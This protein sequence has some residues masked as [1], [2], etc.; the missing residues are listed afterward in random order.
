MK[1]GREEEK[2]SSGANKKQLTISSMFKPAAATKAPVMTAPQVVEGDSTSVE[3]VQD[4]NVKKDPKALFKN[5]DEETL[6]LLDLE[7]RTMNYEW[8]KVLASELTKPYFI[9]VKRLF[10]FFVLF[11]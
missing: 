2:T 4:V 8:L 7:L 10:P 11:R 6:E 1:R 5:V 3:E 9:K